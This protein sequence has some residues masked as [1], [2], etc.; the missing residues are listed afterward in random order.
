MA[1]KI[2]TSSGPCDCCGPAT[3]CSFYNHPTPR[4]IEEGENTNF[5]GA[6]EDADDNPPDSY[7]WQVSVGGGAWAD[8][9]DDS[10]HSGATTDSLSLT[11]V[12]F[13]YDGRAY[14]LAAICGESTTY[15]DG[16]ALE[17]TECVEV[18]PS[19]TIGGTQSA[20]GSESGVSLGAIDPGALLAADFDLSFAPGDWYLPDAR[21]SLMNITGSGSVTGTPSFTWTVLGV[22]VLIE[23]VDITHSS[24][25]YQSEGPHQFGGCSGVVYGRI[26]AVRQLILVLECSNPAHSGNYVVKDWGPSL[27][28]NQFY[29]PCYANGH[30]CPE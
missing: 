3:G 18:E 22:G 25:H 27:E 1:D 19:D 21:E 8:V 20:S 14:R 17:V 5:S 24:Y 16:A 26:F 12:P 13:G 28:D 7:Q 29:T 23:G 6:A 30:H 9:T 10:V 15:S 11:N 4:S 2:I